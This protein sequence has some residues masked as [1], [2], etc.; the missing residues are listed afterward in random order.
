M[1]IHHFSAGTFCP[2][3]GRLLSG[4]GSVFERAELVCH[5][6][7]IETD[8]HGLVL[9]D[10]GLGSADLAN[11]HQ[12]LG[13][14]FL[15]SAAP[16]LDPAGTALAFVV[17]LGFRAA[18]VRHVLLTHMDLDHAGGISDFPAASIHVL[19]DEHAAALARRTFFERNRYHT[20]QWAHGP[21]FVLHGA[22]GERWRGFESVRG[23]PGLPNEILL[24]PLSGHTRGHMCVAVE[25]AEG[26]LVHAG[27]AYFHR[28]SVRGEAPPPPVLAFYEGLI[29]ID[30]AKIRDNHRR[31]R[32][33]AGA[34]D[35]TIF[36]AH[37]PVELRQLA[38]G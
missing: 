32:E 25:H 16:K 23:V 9:V 11:P 4:T 3:G 28:N 10:T 31:L 33:L 35:I 7:L 21:R 18:D 19:A 34:E 2:V 30:K 37:D 12:R 8:A 29:A 6:L 36:C 24:V 38:S 1:K 22:S 26:A 5:C 17:R 14:G 13:A 27:D 15:I 20:C